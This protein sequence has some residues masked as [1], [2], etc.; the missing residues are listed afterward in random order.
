MNELTQNAKLKLAGELQDLAWRILQGLFSWVVGE[1]LFEEGNFPA[2]SMIQI[3][4]GEVIVSGVRAWMDFPTIHRR[5]FGGRCKI[6][7]NPNFQ[8]ILP[9]L[10]VGPADAFILFRFEESIQFR[11]LLDL[12]GIADDEF[13]RLIYLYSAVGILHVEEI[14]EDRIA[15]RIP[16]KIP[17]PQPRVDTPEKPPEEESHPDPKLIREE[18]QVL[19]QQ[20]PV[21]EFAPAAKI[22]P[23]AGKDLGM[24][25]YQCAINSF[26]SKNYWAAVEYCRK[27]LE[28]KKEG[29]IY[30]L[31]G[32]A[33]ATHRAFHHEAMEAY[34]KAQEKDPKSFVIERDIADLYF[35]TGNYALARSRYQAVLKK[36]PEDQHSQ[37][38]LK[39]ILRL[40]K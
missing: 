20:P 13:Y 18:E 31:M 34:K 21:A 15:P 11:E 28:S 27:A 1:F 23:P 24:Y 39:E 2:Q 3:R 36:N 14:T 32:N 29:R 33:L 8:K 5:L 25:Y 22:V 16:R 12:S 40:K 37:Q 26:E 17:P 35:Q 10:S 9:V 30:R 7:L 6:S 19:K 38:R 4:T